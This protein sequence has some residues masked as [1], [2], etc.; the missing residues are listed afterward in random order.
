MALIE[1]SEGDTHNICSSFF[2]NGHNLGTEQKMPV[3]WHFVMGCVD[4]FV[5]HGGFLCNENI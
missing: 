4:L 2:L 5:I 3:F 1:I